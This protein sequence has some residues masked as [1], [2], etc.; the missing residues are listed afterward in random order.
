M[1]FLIDGSWR[2]DWYDTES[3]GGRFERKDS[4]FR[5]WITADGQ[6]GPTGESGFKAEPGRYLLYV[7]YACPW[8]Q[9]AL[10]F[11]ALKQ[12]ESH[13]A[14]SVTHWHMGEHG[15]MFTNG[16][17]EPCAEPVSEA[18]YV[19]QIYQAADPDYT[20]SASVPV[21]WD[22][23]NNTI[24]SNE[25]ADIIRMLNSAFDAVGAA[26]GD[27]YPADLREEIDA[28]NDRIYETVNNGVY[29][30]GFATTQKAYEEAIGP[31]FET[32]DWLDKRLARQRFLTGDRLTEADWRLFPTLI[33]F[34]PVY[35][36]HFKCNKRRIVD[37]PNLWPYVCDLYQHPGIASTVRMDHIKP[38]YYVSHKTINPTGIVPVGPDIDF[39]EV[40][41]RQRL[42]A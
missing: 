41:N 24:V 7:S 31:L 28:L 27:F 16:Q 33:R 26:E 30:A 10:I 35:F 38:H 9:R 18:D 3:T 4:K 17:E 25:S 23:Q 34:D 42:A 11:R 6:A 14:L 32:L 5:N 22:K 40:Q 19:Y 1:G 8:S 12:L 20:G 2:D 37:Y 29:K 15:W 21:L 39:G 36:G 13:I